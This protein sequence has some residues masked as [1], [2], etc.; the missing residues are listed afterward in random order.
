MKTFTGEDIINC[1]KELDKRLPPDSGRVTVYMIGGGAMATRY[2]SARVTTDIDYT[3]TGSDTPAALTA[4]IAAT[5]DRLGLKPDW[6]NNVAE[7]SIPRTPDDEQQTVYKGDNLTVVAAGYRHL[8]AMKLNAGRDKDVQDLLTLCEQ[9][10]IDHPDTLINI[11]AEVCDNP[12]LLKDRRLRK[13]ANRVCNHPRISG[14]ETRVRILPSGQSEEID[15][16]VRGANISDGRTPPK[17]HGH[18]R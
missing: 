2:D 5:S 15:A 8:I 9:N 6:M 1:F 3:T 12:A 7:S 16:P 18:E 14:Q 10:R 4:G 17:N 11:A 13:T